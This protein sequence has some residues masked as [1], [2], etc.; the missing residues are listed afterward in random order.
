MFEIVPI[1][2]N[3]NIDFLGRRRTRRVLVSPSAS[4]EPARSRVVRGPNLGIDFAGGSLVH[5][6]LQRTRGGERSASTRRALRASSLD[7]QD[8]GAT[9]RE[10]WSAC[11]SEEGSDERRGR[12]SRTALR[13]AFGAESGRHPAH[14]SRR[15]AGRRGAAR[16]RRSSPILLATLMMGIYIWVRFEWRFGSRRP[17][18]AILHDVIIVVGCADRLRLRVR[19]QHRRLAAHRGRASR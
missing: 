7:I 11:L 8:F 14:R 1:R 9:A 18:V 19:P 12:G 15:P 17:A 3:T 6:A 5:V 4:R 13:E 10:F 16:R 2:S